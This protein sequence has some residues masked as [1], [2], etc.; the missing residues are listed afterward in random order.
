[1][2]TTTLLL[3]VILT[4]ATACKTSSGSTN[5]QPTSTEESVQESSSEAPPGDAFAGCEMTQFTSGWLEAACE[6]AR[7]LIQPDRAAL[8]TIDQAW[9]PMS[10]ALSEEFD[11]DVF[12]EEYELSIDGKAVPAR[13]FS[14][15]N[16]DGGEPLAKGIYALWEM[17]KTAK[18]AAA[19]IQAPDEFEPAR[20]EAGFTSLKN[21]G[22][23]GEPK[24]EEAAASGASVVIAGQAIVL[25]EDCDLASER[26]IS[27]ESGELTWYQGEADVAEQK[28]TR[29]LAD[30]KD[31]ASAGGAEI[32]ET[33]R[34]CS[35]GD[36]ETTC[37]AYDI[38]SDA[39]HAKFHSA[40]VELDG[41]SLAVACWHDANASM[42]TAC[43]SLFGDEN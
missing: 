42:P 28:S 9:T 32:T 6:D 14:V 22:I 13:T 23:P 35:I 24:V 7:F 39:Q 15:A 41:E 31:V 20:C 16:E 25:G 11:A 18:M 19:C 1:M 33:Q 29:A 36:Y 10:K 21:E 37:H 4:M 26:K 2:K 17:G 38:S 43:A 8:A 27:C 30:M 40:V 12:G 3:T 34:P 5:D